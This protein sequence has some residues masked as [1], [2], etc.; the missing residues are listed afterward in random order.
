MCFLSRVPGSA[1]LL[2]GTIVHRPTT[3]RSRYIVSDFYMCLHGVVLCF[4]AG[5]AFFDQTPPAR[6]AARPR[7]LHVRPSEPTR[8]YRDP[9]H[10]SYLS[11]S[12][13]VSTLIPATPC[14]SNPI[15]RCVAFTAMIWYDD[16]WC[17]GTWPERL[18]PSA[19]RRST[20]GP[21]SSRWG[22]ASAPCETLGIGSGRGRA[23][24]GGGAH[25]EMPTHYPHVAHNFY[26][27]MRNAN[28]SEVAPMYEV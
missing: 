19:S 8:L 4:S 20:S 5:T 13:C 22:D 9:E 21:S 17:S 18:C 24:R 10:L 6:P 26:M 14:E 27:Y 11:R 12:T 7:T 28:G 3:A 25:I 16:R 1:T 2:F 23:G 15:D